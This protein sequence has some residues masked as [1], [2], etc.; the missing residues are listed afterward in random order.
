MLGLPD[1]FE[2]L[3]WKTMW[4]IARVFPL[5]ASVTPYDVA[6]I[7][8]SLPFL[9]DYRIISLPGP[10]RGQR[11]SPDSLIYTCDVSGGL[12]LRR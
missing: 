10:F 9:L 12:Q 3:F 7:A 2:R 6:G 1:N 11:A 4:I 5:P 8:P